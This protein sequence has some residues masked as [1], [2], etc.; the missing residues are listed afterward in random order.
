VSKVLAAARR[1]R[2]LDGQLRLLAKF[3]REL[4]LQLEAAREE[5]GRAARQWQVRVHT[6]SRTI[7]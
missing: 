4:L 7:D 2:A 1:S 3:Q 6:T 5:A